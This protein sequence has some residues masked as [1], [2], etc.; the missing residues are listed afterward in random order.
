[1]GAWQ[2]ILALEEGKVLSKGDKEFI[3]KDNN[4]MK[5]Y[6][7]KTNFPFEEMIMFPERWK[8]IS[9]KKFEKIFS[10]S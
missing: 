9:V 2:L 5:H 4:E 1:M 6:L 3:V 10:Y 8:I 7:K